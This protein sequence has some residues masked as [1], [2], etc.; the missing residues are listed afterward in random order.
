M[1]GLALSPGAACPEH[2]RDRVQAAWRGT[3]A[4]AGTAEGALCLPSCLTEAGCEACRVTQLREGRIGTG[5]APLT[6]AVPTLCP[7]ASQAPRE[8]T[9]PWFLQSL[10]EREALAWGQL[11]AQQCQP[12]P[13]VA[14]SRRDPESPTP[15]MCVLLPAARS[16]RVGNRWLMPVWCPWACFWVS[17]GARSSGVGSYP[18]HRFPRGPYSVAVRSTLRD[19][20]D[21][22]Q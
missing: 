14:S 15:P 21:R 2:T 5:R 9:V 16:S 19:R 18:E 11:P 22:V 4:R 17:E 13:G 7:L 3:G 6:A 20:T 12:D 8:T 1:E 10:C